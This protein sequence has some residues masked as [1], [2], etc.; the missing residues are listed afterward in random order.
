MDLTPMLDHL[1]QLEWNNNREWFRAHAKE[2]KEAR[3][4]F[5]G[6]VFGMMMGLA[7]EQPGIL[8]FRPSTLTYSLVRDPRRPHEEGPYHS[9]MRATVG[10]WGRTPIPVSHFLRVQPGGRSFIGGGLFARCFNDATRMVRDRIVAE[11]EVWEEIVTAPEFVRCFGEIYGE[12][13]KRNPMGYDPNHPHIEYLKHKNWYVICP[14]PDELFTDSNVLLD[15][16]LEAC[17]AMRPM[18]DFLNAA[19]KGFKMPEW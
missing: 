6:L 4:D 7:Q 17:Y 2:R 18:N 9:A 15:R 8:D 19:M 10:P 3:A 14:L 12:K 11:A 13:L 1:A 5:E 16:I